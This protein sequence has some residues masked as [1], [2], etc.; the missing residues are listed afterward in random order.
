MSVIGQGQERTGLS[1]Y[2][3]VIYDG[4]PPSRE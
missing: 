2:D 3:A 1:M 4:F